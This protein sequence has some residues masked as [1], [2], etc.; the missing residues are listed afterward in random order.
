MNT[1]RIYIID[2]FLKCY[3]GQPI[4]IQKK[5]KGFLIVALINI[6]FMPLMIPVILLK[7]DNQFG[8]SIAV[9]AIIIDMFIIAVSIYLL[10][11]DK[12]R[13]ASYLYIFAIP[14]AVSIII[15]P[16]ANTEFE[17][18]KLVCSLFV[19]LCLVGLISNS[20][21]Q[22]IL[23]IAESV[24]A[25]IIFS[26]MVAISH[27]LPID[28]LFIREFLTVLIL[29]LLGSVICFFLLSVIEERIAD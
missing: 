5:A 24:L 10:A 12:R 16:M 28:M 4:E 23:Y 15:F 3:S 19:G 8:N 13:L 2:K 20:R 27:K 14:P 29:F 25:T 26:V 1:G 11:R 22:V 9:T 6:I 17:I 21:R 7:Q 18:S